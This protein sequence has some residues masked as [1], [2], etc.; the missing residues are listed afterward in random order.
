MNKPNEKLEAVFEA[1]L[2]LDTD[3]QRADYLNRACPE[4]EL[5]R[6]VESLLEAHRNPDSIFVEKTVRVT[7]PLSEGP[8]TVIGRYTLLQIIGD[9]GFGV[10]YM[11]EQKEPVRRRVAL[12]IIKQGMDTQQ[13]V[14]RFEAERQA[15]AMMDHPNIAKV[16]DG[17]A[18]EAP[19]PASGH[20]LHEPTPAPLPGGELTTGRCNEAPLLGGVGGARGGF[21]RG[22]FSGQGEGSSSASAHSALPTLSE[23]ERSPSRSPHSA[24]PPGRPF[25]VME[26][27]K[28]QTVTKYCDEHHLSTRQRLE[29]F[30][31]ICQAIQHAHQKGIIHR[32]IKPSNILVA[33]IDGRPVPKVIDF[34]IAKAT[35]HDLTDK[36]VFTQFHQFMGTPAY[37]SPEQ[38]AMDSSDI[39][40][41]SDIY[42]L[43]VQLYELLTGKTP[44]EA[45]ELTRGGF[46]EIRRRIREI[47]PP[48]PSNRLTTLTNDELTT[49]ARSRAIEPAKL[50]KLIR[51]EL[52]WVVLKAMDKDRSRRYETASAFALDIRRYL[53]NEPVTAVKPSPIYHLQK[54]ARRHQVA[55]ATAA[56]FV[57]LL[58]VGI[59]VATAQA[60]TNKSLF[61]AAEEA[62][63]AAMN[64]Q[65]REIELRRIA[66]TERGK[67]ET[68]RDRSQ[69]FLY[70]A[71]MNL[72]K[73]AWDEA[74][75]GLVEKLLELHHP[76]P[77]QPD[78]RN[79]EWFY[80]DR[81][82]H[83]ELLTLKGHT[84]WVSSVAFSP[85]GKRLASASGDQTV[86]VWDVTGGQKTLTL[87]GHSSFV[88]CV[89]FSP[90][91]K[92]LASASRDK[93]IKVWDATSGQKALTLR[94]HT[95]GVRTLGPSGVLS[96]AFSPDGK[97]LAS[98]SQDRTVKVWDATSGQEMLTLK[99]H[100][101]SVTSVAFSPD[102]KLL[103]SASEDKTV[104]VWN[105]VNGQERLTLRGHDWPVLSVVF[106]TDGKRL[107][108][109]S[110][111]ETAKVWDS[112]SGQEMFTL[113]GHTAPVWSVAFS[114][115]GKRLASASAD[116]TTK[117]WDA[118]SGQEILTLRGHGSEIWSV[119]FS[120]D[121][122][123]LAT[124][125]K[126][127]TVKV[128]DAT[129]APAPFTFKGQAS[130]AF[131]VDGKWLAS[132]IDDRTV[133][134]WDTTRGQ[135]ILSLQGRTNRIDRAANKVVGIAFSPDGKQLA[136]A[137][138][139]PSNTRRPGE[140]SVW[141]VT[142]GQ[143]TLT[144]K[145][146]SAGVSGV[147]FS[148]N[149]RSLASASWDKTVKVWDTTSGQETI[150]LRGHT[151]GVNS[152]AISPDGKR[153]ASGSD[154]K[155][156]KVWDFTTGQEM[157]TLKGHD[158]GL[159]AV[160]FSPDGKWLASA[161]SHAVKLWDAA[162][163]QATLTLEG[164]GDWIDDLAFS[165]D[166]KRLAS[167]S[168]DKTVKVWDVTT[169]Q[170]TLTLKHDAPVI[171]VAF[172]ADG[173]RLA[174]A[175]WAGTVKLW[176]ARPRSEARTP[177]TKTP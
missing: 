94:G 14:A 39:D 29:L 13:V 50:S 74:N 32:D 70:I 113:R 46:D 60:I 165:P 120:A 159:T 18:T 144:L 119:T 65:E 57:L 97:R 107:A 4:P 59:C 170:E 3:T 118:T 171:G 62:K 103:A 95:N 53:D 140:V 21:M 131:S 124:A 16:L 110:G 156:V 67:A 137:G 161:D 142:T 78:L 68:E 71:H 153:L 152:V 43:G 106:S 47:E 141:D 86:K 93:T 38:A 31:P 148:P 76:Q 8:G 49:V 109:A 174:S 30:I 147:A 175:G 129:D 51:G 11:A 9:G 28:G 104:K 167:A 54:F 87:T 162:S 85:D 12:K 158:D 98:A 81:L 149:G 90:D 7:P 177:E 20:P 36:I 172:S 127:R 61:T 82:A 126:D 79:F 96:V 105:S 176:D 135:E 92:W 23:P 101:N 41:R 40:T 33:T 83:S 48:R 6:E 73:R 157:L 133:T 136:S 164:H 45:K 134:V 145:G 66:E 17:G 139:T 91:G 132:A 35:Q 88:Y 64:G 125:C 114:P 58:T 34:G 27:V 1:A 52:D 2:A 112:A 102:G 128:W 84:N 24:I 146:H 151:D 100:T 22:V 44:V 168:E 166:G 63:L 80:L 5:R 123:R 69:S 26:L 77:G 25:F 169:G 115:D 163:G 130:V 143:Q 116:R 138:G 15:L 173:K 55:L 160:M 122:K 155:T 42:S 56:C 121:G 108:S 10:V 150:T 154:D 111:D 75:V 37:M 99:G 89:A 72:A 117:V 19:L